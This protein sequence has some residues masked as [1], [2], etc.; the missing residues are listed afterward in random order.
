MNTLLGVEMR[1]LGRQLA[2]LASQDRYA[3]ELSRGQLIEALIE[4]TAV[5]RCTAHTFATWKFQNT[6]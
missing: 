5:F 3:R 2:E 4:V 6:R 1:S